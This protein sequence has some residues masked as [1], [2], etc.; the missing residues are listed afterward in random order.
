MKYVIDCYR[1]AKPG[2]KQRLHFHAEA[3]ILFFTEGKGTFHTE[4]RDYSFK[5]GTAIIVPARMKHISYSSDD[6][7]TITVADEGQKIMAET[8]IVLRD[9]EE[10]DGRTLAKLL[11]RY[12]H[13][14]SPF[15]TDLINAYIR[16][17]LQR[18]ELPGATETAL[19]E[20]YRA[21]LENAGDKDLDLHAILTAGGYAEDYIRMLFKKRYGIPP[22]KFLAQI[23]MENACFLLDTYR[24]L[25]L[26]EIAERCGY[27][28]YVY[29]S[30]TFKAHIGKSPREYLKDLNVH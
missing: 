29:F 14:R 8:P 4:Q 21:L 20:V 2:N 13:V 6:F 16:F 10:G 19:N 12:R 7:V 11:F 27:D 26:A 28:D 18:A 1:S 17:W 24:D 5:P 30:K 3:E 15:V 25:P 9:N 23:R 22:L